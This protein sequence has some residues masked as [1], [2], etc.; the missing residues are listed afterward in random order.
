MKLIY[1]PDMTQSIS[2][3][4]LQ[5][6][7]AEILAQLAPHNDIVIEDGGKPIARLAAIETSVTS[8]SPH[9]TRPMGFF[10]GQ[11]WTAPD[12]DAELPEGFWCPPDDP[13][14]K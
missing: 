13:L 11:I 8:P 9:T 12:F 4:D 5:E 14:T 10:K 1:H 3:K 7:T 2:I 6:H